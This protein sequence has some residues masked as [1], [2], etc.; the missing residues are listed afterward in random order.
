MH[1]F[2]QITRLLYINCP[3]HDLWN[4]LQKLSHDSDDTSRHDSKCLLFWCIAQ[5]N[6]YSRSKN[7]KFSSHPVTI[8]CHSP[9]LEIALAT[10]HSGFPE[11]VN[12][13]NLNTLKYGQGVSRVDLYQFVVLYL[14]CNC[15]HNICSNTTL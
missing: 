6:I 1:S 10:I 11:T 4:S 8:N 7:S 3:S 14:C 5:F 2:M 12:S 9:I 13:L 15:E